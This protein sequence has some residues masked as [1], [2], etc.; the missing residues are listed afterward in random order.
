MKQTVYLV[1]LSQL[2]DEVYASDLSDEEFK[3]EAIKQ[4]TTYSLL[5]FQ[6]AF[7]EGFINEEDGNIRIL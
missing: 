4:G 1:S 3:K 5:E 2:K 6:A 7:N